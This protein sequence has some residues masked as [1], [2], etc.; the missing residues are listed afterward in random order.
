M[1]RPISQKL[2]T[3]DNIRR[4]IKR[5]RI[6]C[7]HLLEQIL[8]IIQALC[9]EHVELH[10]RCVGAPDL[11]FAHVFGGAADA[12]DCGEVFVDFVGRGSVRGRTVEFVVRLNGSKS[13]RL[14]FP[15]PF[16]DD[17]LLLTRQFQIDVNIIQQHENSVQV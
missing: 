4:R 9:H 8:Q 6:T 10:Q 15:L 3:T 17:S 13:A 16:V 12:V 2:P 11:G 5:I 7:Q 1:G 14:Q